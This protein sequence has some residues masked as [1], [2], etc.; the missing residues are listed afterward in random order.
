MVLLDHLFALLHSEAREGEHTNLLC[1]MLPR[2]LGADVLEVLTEQLT[3]LSDSICHVNEL[4]EPLSA[5][6]RLVQDEGSNSSAMK[7]RRRVLSSNDDL[8]LGENLGGSA[9][10]TADEVKST[11][12]LT[13]KTHDLGERLGDA[14]L[15]ALVEEVSQADTVLI[16]VTGHEALIGSVKE[17]IESVLVANSSDLL[18]L[19]KSR[20]DTSRVV[21]AGVEKHRG[22]GSG[23]FKILEHSLEIE[24]LSLLVEVAVLANLKSGGLEDLVMVTPS[25]V[26]DIDGSGSVLLEEI[27]D[28]TESTGTRESLRGSNSTA[29]DISVIP[30]EEG[31]AGTLVEVL[32][33]I[34]GRVFLV[35]LGVVDDHLLSLADNGEDV[36]LTILRSVSTDTKVDFLGELV[37]LVAGR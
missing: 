24:T 13:V 1:D 21:S 29:G 34:N 3:H 30:T 15:E 7:R 14:H 35:K 26:A 33:A 11:S 6:I 32:V 12:T 4:L 37:V 18:P 27:T 22:A 36:R 10:V 31:H 16:Q 8:K 5:E 20:I 17:G 2:A 9:L 19:I 25:R 28:N 23:V